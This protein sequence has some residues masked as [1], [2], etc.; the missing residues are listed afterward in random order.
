MA[1]N[2]S[3]ARRVSPV[4][5]PRTP[6][7]SVGIP[8]TRR[9]T[10]AKLADLPLIGNQTNQQRSQAEKSNPSETR[11]EPHAD[12]PALFRQRELPARCRDL[13]SGHLQAREFVHRSSSSSGPTEAVSSSWRRWYGDCRSLE[14]P[15]LA[16][17]A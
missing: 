13:R 4:T 6:E 15:R 17:P 16:V 5:T 8:T 12:A 9:K 7:T 14:V 10:A 1:T 11:A 3:V 2:W